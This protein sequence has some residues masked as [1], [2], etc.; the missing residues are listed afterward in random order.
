M[1]LRVFASGS[2]GNCLLLSSGSTHILIDAGISKRRIEQS[3]AQSGLSMREIGGVLITHEHSD[4]ISGLKMLTKYYDLPVFAP[5][6][7]AS[8]L[9]GCLPEAEPYLRVIPVN[10]PFEIGGVSVTAFHTPHDTDESVGYRVQS[11]GVFALATD[12]GHVTEEVLNALSGADAVLIESNHDEEMLRYGP[13]PVYLKR[14]I[15]SDSGHLSNACCADLARK[16]ALG[17]TRQI[18]LGHL[19]R[20]NNS[21]A[22]AMSAAREST[23]G[24]PVELY[25][26]PVYGCLSLKVGEGCLCSR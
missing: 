13:Y 2:S 20:E 4:H 19:S 5:R 23:A 12:M 10:E 25:C 14:R 3:L 11:G 26:A 9:R 7:V 15:L 24:L 22:I 6:T 21:P 17:G 18:I 1:E 16:L 8:R